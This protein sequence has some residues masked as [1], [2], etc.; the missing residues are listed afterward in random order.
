MTTLVQA[1]SRIRS[2]EVTALEVSRALKD[3]LYER[4]RAQEVCV[5]DTPATRDTSLVRETMMVQHYVPYLP[6]TPADVTEIMH[7]YLERVFA[8]R[9]AQWTRGGKVEWGEEVV[10]WLVEQVVFVTWEDGSR[11]AEEGAGGV[12]AVVTRYV[13]TTLQ[14]VLGAGMDG[15]PRARMRVEV[16]GPGGLRAVHEVGR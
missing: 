8:P 4:W 5:R 1:A 7:D 2:G 13:T 15:V 11:Y 14:E 16:K 10:R 6:L 12:A 3:M 9:F